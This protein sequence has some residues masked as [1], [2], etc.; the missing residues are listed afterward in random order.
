MVLFDEFGFDEWKGDEDMPGKWKIMNGDQM[1]FQDYW[2]V[3]WFR[4]VGVVELSE[5]DEIFGHM[6]ELNYHN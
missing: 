6:D 4:N 3:L 1:E 2:Y 5:N